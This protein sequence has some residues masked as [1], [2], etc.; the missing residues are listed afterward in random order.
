[1]R[2]I[3]NA[4]EASA[5][6]EMLAQIEIA[7]I[8]F[9]NSNGHLKVKKKDLQEQVKLALGQPVKMERR[10]SVQARNY[11]KQAPYKRSTVSGGMGLTTKQINRG[12]NRLLKYKPKAFSWIDQSFLSQ[13][14][15]TAYKELLSERYGKLELGDKLQ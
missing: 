13:D 1:M 10:L 5:V 12:F 3:E 7:L 8:Q 2:M 14:M 4:V 6:N 11:I 9:L 15:K